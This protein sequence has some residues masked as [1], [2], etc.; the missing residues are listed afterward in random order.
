MRPH[1]HAHS[2][3][4]ILPSMLLTSRALPVSEGTESGIVG[5]TIGVTTG[6]ADVAARGGGTEA[7]I[8][9]VGGAPEMEAPST[10]AAAAVAGMGETPMESC[11]AAAA[12]VHAAGGAPPRRPASFAVVS[13]VGDVLIAPFWPQVPIPSPRL[14]CATDVLLFRFAIV[15]SCIRKRRSPAWH[16]TATSQV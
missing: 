3:Q 9:S 10:A 4:A 11:E 13:L 12:A 1:P 16:V 8:H 6:G 15:P 2:A 5:A 7:D 14:S